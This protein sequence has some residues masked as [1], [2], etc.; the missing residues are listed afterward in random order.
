MSRHAILTL[1]LFIGMVTFLVLAACGSAAQ[2]PSSLVSDGDKAADGNFANSG[3]LA[4]LGPIEPLELTPRPSVDQ[5]QRIIL[6]NAALSIVVNDPG[7]TL[8]SISS[9]AEEMGGWVVN[10]T[11][12]RVVMASGEEVKRGSHTVRVPAERLDEAI[13]RIKSGAGTVNSEN[14]SGQDVTQEYTDLTS[15]LTNLEA[16]E[17]QLRAIME[18]AE[19]TEDVLKVYD[20]LVRVR[21]EI[22]TTRGRIQYY[23][24][25]AAFSSISVDIIPKAIEA[26]V[27]IAGWSPGRT[28]QEAIAALINILRGL[29]DVLIIVVIVGVPLA[30]IVGIPGWFIYRSLRRRRAHG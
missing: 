1:R 14:V 8:T 25:A 12:S 26:P 28:A 27:Q 21:G 22:E 17:K 20:E 24:Q 7:A 13:E 6:R 2:P 16:A 10:S 18:Q 23:D 19:K 5:Q 3:T 11:T 9:M 15:Q 4:R 30:L 29:A